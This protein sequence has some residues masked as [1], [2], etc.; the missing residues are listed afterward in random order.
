MSNESFEFLQQPSSKS[1]ATPSGTISD[2]NSGLR[3][4]AASTSQ[5]TS[6]SPNHSSTLSSRQQEQIKKLDDIVERFRTNEITKPKAV[7]LLLRTIEFNPDVTDK[8]KEQ[9]FDLY[10]SNLDAYETA[11]A[12]SLRRGSKY[13]CAPPQDE[14]TQTGLTG[15]NP[16]PLGEPQ[17]DPDADRRINDFVD[18]LS[19]GHSPIH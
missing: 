17:G 2:G 10:L 5:S 15:S 6:R 13:P 7:A 3:T 4:N 11:A 19:R 18:D 14:E 16:C 9:A 1:S 12:E 8:S